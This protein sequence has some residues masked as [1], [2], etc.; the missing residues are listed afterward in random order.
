MSYKARDNEIRT[1]PQAEPNRR[2]LFY[3]M[4][5]WI[6]VMSIHIKH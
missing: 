6:F 5:G 2:N 3:N 4:D 1:P